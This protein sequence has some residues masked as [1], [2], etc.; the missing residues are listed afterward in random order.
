MVRSV[1][2]QAFLPAA[3]FCVEATMRMRWICVTCLSL[4]GCIPLPRMP[5]EPPTQQVA[6]S[7]NEPRRALP[8]RVQYAPASNETSLRVML[9]K[10]KLTGDNPQLGIKPYVVAI[11]SNDPEVFHVGLNTIYVTD[12]LV[13]QCQTDNQLA[14]VIANELGRM[15]SE[16]ESRVGD[17]VRQPE[18][19][20]P[21]HLPIGGGGNAFEADPLHRIELAQFEK[22]Y[23]KHPK[24]L[25]A[26]N[27]QN[28]AREILDRAGYQRTDLDAAWPILQNAQ[29]FQVMESQF[30]GI[31]N[32]NGWKAP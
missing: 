7:L 8:T 18:R 13:Q 29:R 19:M 12:G 4:T 30:K 23:P 28:V 25:P 21:V 3:W 20:R 26:P 9:I 14:A 22:H 24:G 17:D 2:G 16:R 31:P 11:R 5:D 6:S 27:P 15:I 10:D 32:Q 1:V